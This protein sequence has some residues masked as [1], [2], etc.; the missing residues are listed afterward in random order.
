MG[1]SGE[2]NEHKPWFRSAEIDLVGHMKKSVVL[3]HDMLLFERMSKD[4]P[5]KTYSHLL[6]LLRHQAQKDMIDRSREVQT[7]TREAS[8]LGMPAETQNR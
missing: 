8:M 7:R 4:D 6:A 2:Q 3:K 5:N 1:A